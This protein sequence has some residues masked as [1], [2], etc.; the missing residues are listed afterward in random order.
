MKTK[1]EL[2]TKWIVID[3]LIF[4]GLILSVEYL[5]KFLDWNWSAGSFMVGYFIYLLLDA[6]HPIPDTK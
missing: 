1:F 5:F 6:I 2:D 3:I 4:L